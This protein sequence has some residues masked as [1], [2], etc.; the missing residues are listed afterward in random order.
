MSIPP[1]LTSEILG[2][3]RIQVFHNSN[4]YWKAWISS[5][6]Q[7]LSFPWSDRVTLFIFVEMLAKTQVWMTSFVC[8]SLHR[9]TVLCGKWL[10]QPVT[11]M[12]QKCFVCISHFLLRSWVFKK[13][14]MFI[15]SLK[16]F[17]VKLALGKWSPEPVTAV[18]H[19]VPLL[20]LAKLLALTHHC[21][22]IFNVNVNTKTNK[23]LDH[24]KKCFP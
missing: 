21:F 5:W 24:H 1:V 20:W 22:C 6:Q 12:Q 11:G 3:G 16:P 8:Q 14:I 4:F 2:R 19:W 7:I 15:A 17:L 23:D 9:E 13:G 18:S 10:V